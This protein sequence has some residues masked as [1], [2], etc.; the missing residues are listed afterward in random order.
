MNIEN[1]INA[2]SNI[3]EYLLVKNQQVTSFLLI[4]EYFC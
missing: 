3:L 1:G 2:F 4:V